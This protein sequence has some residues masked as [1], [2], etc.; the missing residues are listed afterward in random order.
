M[1]KEGKWLQTNAQLMRGRRRGAKERELGR[2]VTTP[3]PTL[4]PPNSLLFHK[5]RPPTFLNHLTLNVYSEEG[6]EG[7]G[8]MD[9]DIDKT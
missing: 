7:K 3:P 6:N 8:T 5:Q 9:I 2:G 4:H 1:Y